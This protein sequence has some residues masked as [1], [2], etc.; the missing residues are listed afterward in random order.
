MDD[1]KIVAP[2]KISL[3][4]GGGSQTLPPWSVPH[5]SQTTILGGE[6]SLLGTIM[7]IPGSELRSRERGGPIPDCVI[8]SQS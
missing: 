8:R 7:R 5:G 1:S 2:P 6:S 4:M 3:D